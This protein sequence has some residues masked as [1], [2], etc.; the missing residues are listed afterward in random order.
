MTHA[1]YFRRF[2]AQTWTA[3]GTAVRVG[4][5]GRHIADTGPHHTPAS[6]YPAG[7]AKQD[8]AHARFIASAPALFRA[9]QAV[10]A[11]SQQADESLMDEALDALQTAVL[12]TLK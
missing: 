11:A 2:V 7:L 8:E 9:S 6:E 12:E 1:N 4:T 5:N 10:L 3:N